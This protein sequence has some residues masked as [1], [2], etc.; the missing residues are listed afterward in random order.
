MVRFG[1]I[2]LRPAGGRLNA[3]PPSGFS[4]LAKIRRRCRVFTHLTPHLFRNFCENFDPMPCEVRSP[5]QV[6][7]PNYK[8]TFQSRHCYNVSGKVMKLSEYD[9]L[10]SAYKTFIL[11]FWYRWPQVRS[12]LRP[13]H[14]KSMGKNSNPFY[15]L[16]RKPIWVESCRIG[17]LWTIRVKICV[18]YPSKVHFRSPEVT[19]RHLPITFDQKE[20]EMW[21]WCQY[22]RLGQVNPRPYSVF[23]HL[24]PCRGGGGLV[25]PPPLAFQNK[26]S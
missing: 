23:C 16:W 22:V 17:Q 6:K 9:E 10:I 11:D 20:I 13:P 3:P 24:R 1:L 18:A 4:R 26:R 2:N 12:F 25:R 5:G 8:I 21:D 14:Y 19:N 7:W 15:L